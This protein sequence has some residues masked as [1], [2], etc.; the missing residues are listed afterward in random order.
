MITM[1]QCRLINYKKCTT[2]VWDVGAWGVCMCGHREYGGNV[3][4]FCS[5]FAMNLRSPEGK[6]TIKA[7]GIV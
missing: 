2:L 4:T 3:C 7:K 1:Y 5:I 6:K